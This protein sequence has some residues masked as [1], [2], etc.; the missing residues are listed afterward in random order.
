MAASI[1]AAK[2]DGETTLTGCEAVNNS[3]PSFFHDYLALG[4]IANVI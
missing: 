4:G 1:A 2:A 3:Y